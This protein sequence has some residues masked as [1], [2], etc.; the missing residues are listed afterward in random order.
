MLRVNRRCHLWQFGEGCKG[1]GKQIEVVEIAQLSSPVA[2][3]TSPVAIMNACAIVL[4]LA[5]GSSVLLT[6]VWPVQVVSAVT[7]NSSVGGTIVV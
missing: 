4:Q 6:I 3:C 7:L 5:L 1:A 2:A